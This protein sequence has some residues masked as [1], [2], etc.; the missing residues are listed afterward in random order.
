[1]R[2]GVLRPGGFRTLL[3]G[4][5]VSSL[6][7]WMATIAFM[8]LALALTG[9]SAAVA[10]ILVLRL[11]PAAI[12]G[13]LTAR[14]VPRWNRRNTMLAMDALRAG[15]IA[16]VPFVHALWWIYLWAFVV[17]AASLVFLPARDSSIPDL[18][19]DEDLPLANGL[20]LGSSY[21]TIPLGAAAFALVSLLAAGSVST[22]SSRGV[23]PTFWV[24]AATYVV[25]FALLSRIRGLGTAPVRA[26]QPVEEA[27]PGG[28]LSAFRIPLVRAVA[29]A[30]LSVS[31]GIGALFSLGIVFVR[32]VLHATDI[33]FGVLIALFGVGAG[34]GLA[35]LRRLRS[36][37]MTSVLWCVAGQGVVIAGMSLSPGVPLT[38]LGAAAFGGFTAACLAGAMSLLQE[39]LDGE[40]RVLA[41]AAFHV[42][43][44]VGLTLAALGAGLAA[45]Q[46]EGVRWP[47][48]GMLPPARVVLMCS[49]LFVLAS[50]V[51]TWLK[52]R[53][54]PVVIGPRHDIAGVVVALPDYPLAGPGPAGALSDNVRSEPGAFVL[55]RRPP[56][57]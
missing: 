9:D 57:A 24:D 38:Y 14:I 54:R 10:G 40:Q 41:F 17:E 30:A 21:G 29:P 46:L 7:D 6:G 52:L 20:I 2:G 1:M 12:A 48:L 23:G 16:L 33:Q 15:A 42:V 56:S 27:R 26:V 22:S 3:I 50:A 49:G 31:L 32:E 39:S 34:I 13:P 37:G 53:Q 47:V 36:H 8:A 11:A 35:V 25:S 5:G 18:V 19:P 43:I 51:A 55:P 4:Q 44:R 28:F 45:D